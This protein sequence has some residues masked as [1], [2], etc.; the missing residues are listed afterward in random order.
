MTKRRIL[1]ALCVAFCLILAA[2][3]EKGPE[4]EP[5]KD[6]D[7]QVTPSQSTDAQ[8]TPAQTDEGQSTAFEA[9]HLEELLAADIFSDEIAV[10]DN[11]LVFGLYGLSADA[12]TDCVAY[13]STGASAEELVLFTVADESGVERIESACEWRVEDQ[14]FGYKDYKPTEV[15]KLENAIVEVR[16]NTVLF[17]VAH[18]WEGAAEAVAA[19]D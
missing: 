15:P 5:S 7:A 16:G 6:T 3:G 4:A 13:L 10:V 12:V 17:V 19:L 1:C 9:A 18:D 11:E 2:C 8:V 14:T